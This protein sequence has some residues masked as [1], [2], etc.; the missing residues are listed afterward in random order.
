MLEKAWLGK[1]L[2]A[3]TSKNIRRLAYLYAESG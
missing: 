2:T 3:E 1:Q